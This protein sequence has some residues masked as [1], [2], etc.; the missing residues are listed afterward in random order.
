MRQGNPFSVR[1]DAYAS[2]RPD[3]PAELYAWI[4]GQCGRRDAAWDCATGNGQA[5]LGLAAYFERVQATDVSAEQIAHA[6]PHVA[7]TYSVAPAEESGFPD[8]SF[9]LVSVAQALHWFELPRFWR[10]VSRVC[11]PGA[12]FCAWGYAWPVVGPALEDALVAPVRRALEPFWA[13]NNA[14]LWRGYQVHEIGFPFDNLP[15]PELAIEVR[16]TLD[17]LLRYLRTWSAYK[18]SAA[19]PRA[20]AAL[21]DAEHDAKRLVDPAEVLTVRMPLSIRAGRVHPA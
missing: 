19:D 13:P 20:T 21:L 10:E 4:A 18:H 8:A 12:L 15:T 7:V 6:R 14:I 16:W 11:R 1:S 5:A 17:E 9:D 2:D 3:Y